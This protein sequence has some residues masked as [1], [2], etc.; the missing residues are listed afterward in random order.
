MPQFDWTISL[1]QLVNATMVLLGLAFM[2]QRIYYV[3]DKRVSTIEDKVADF[4]R[5]LDKHA[6]MV[7]HQ[8]AQHVESIQTQ[9]AVHANAVEHQ[10][11]AHAKTLE[12]HAARMERWEATLFNVVADLQRVI[13]RLG[14]ERREE[15]REWN[16]RNR[17][18]GNK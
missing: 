12:D 14:V 11:E 5:E 10:I 4:V 9:I 6:R 15:Q 7:E 16:G 18:D 13:G 17:R 3:L 2:A 8:I 1:G